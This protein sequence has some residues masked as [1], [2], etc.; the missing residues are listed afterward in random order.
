M[1]KRKLGTIEHEQYRTLSTKPHLCD[2]AQSSDPAYPPITTTRGPETKSPSFSRSSPFSKSPFENAAVFLIAF[3]RIEKNSRISQVLL[4]YF[5]QRNN[6]QP[7]GPSMNIA[8]KILKSIG[9]AAAKQGH[10]YAM[11]T[12]QLKTKDGESSATATNGRILA[13]LSWKDDA[14]DFE[15]CANAKQLT[16][17]SKLADA[18]VQV[19]LSEE[20]VSFEQQSL[21]LSSETTKQSLAL[22]MDK[23][24]DY[25]AVIPTDSPLHTICLDP[26]LFIQLLKALD[27]AVSKTSPVFTLEFHDSARPLVIR[28]ESDGVTAVGAIMPIA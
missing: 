28:G 17:F 18:D 6:E 1:H 21:E 3:F 10:Q 9:N 23:F 16:A 2:I 4:L 8:R 20:S 27:P 19:T 25:E 24:P 26:K 11:E 14:V 22:G 13:R 5:R 12:V 15:Q 7:K